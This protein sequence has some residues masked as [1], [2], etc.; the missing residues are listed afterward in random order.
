MS[1]ITRLKSVISEVRNLLVDLGTDIKYPR[2][3]IW[4]TLTGVRQEYCG[5]TQ[6]VWVWKI[7][8]VLFT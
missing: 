7:L 2:Q 4:K 5:G 6:L 3:Y 1:I 8:N